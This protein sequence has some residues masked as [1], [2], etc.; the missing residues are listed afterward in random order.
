MR[1]KLLAAALVGVLLVLAGYA[2]AEMYFEGYMGGVFPTNASFNT[3]TYHYPQRNVWEK[4]DIT[5]RFLSAFQG[6]GKL[7]LWFDKSGVLSGIN[8]RPWMKYFGFYLDLSYHRL[9]VDQDRMKTVC[10]D[11][12]PPGFG[13]GVPGIP[14]SSDF[15]SEGTAFTLAFMFAARYGFLK[16]SEVPF[17]RLQP[18]LAV[19]PALLLSSQNPTINSFRYQAETASFV[20]YTIKPGSDSDVEPCLA[21]ETGLRWMAL[22]NVSV[23]VSFKYRYARPEYGYRYMDISTGSPVAGAPTPFFISNHSITLKPTYH[24]LSFQVGAAYHF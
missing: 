17:G 13:I 5:A 20:K 11:A 7:G 24:L 23:D 4:H 21:V 14:L 16:D 6:G 9:N 12:R 3:T 22:K 8:F 2:Q 10:F 18:Y 1:R 15:M 19:G